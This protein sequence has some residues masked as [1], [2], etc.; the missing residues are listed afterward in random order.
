ML[1]NL[2][3][4]KTGKSCRQCDADSHRVFWKKGQDE[5]GKGGTRRG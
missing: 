2:T 4:R 5:G 1:V 3:E